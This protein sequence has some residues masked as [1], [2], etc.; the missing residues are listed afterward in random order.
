MSDY[1]RIAVLD[2]EVQAKLLEAVLMERGIPFRIRSYHDL[3]YDGLFQ[4]QKGWGHIE[5]P[6]EYL[7]AILTV[8]KDLT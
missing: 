5:A 6:S 1:L 3:V 4:N 7:N 8:L 2:N